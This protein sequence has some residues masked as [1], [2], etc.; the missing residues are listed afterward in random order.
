MST[1]TNHLRILSLLFIYLTTLA[2]YDLT[3]EVRDR[4]R[5]LKGLLSSAGVGIV[6]E[7]TEARMR[8]SDEDFS[9]GVQ[10][11]EVLEE[12]EERNQEEER[13]MT[14]EQVR[15][16]LFEGKDGL[17]CNSSGKILCL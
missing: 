11:E 9:R 3:Y 10:V 12:K 14:A 16:V 15:V 8:L 17:T 13:T 2:R 7:G 1:L 6:K 4:A 5:Y